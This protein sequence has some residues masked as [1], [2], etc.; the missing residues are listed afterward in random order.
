MLLFGA[1][2]HAKVL[3]SCLRAAD[4]EI[5]GIF[6][7]APL[8]KT[9]FNVPFPGIYDFGFCPDE[10]L[11]IAIGD[12]F[13][14]RRISSRIH[15]RFGKL[16][17]PSAIIDGSVNVLEGS[18]ILHRSVLQADTIVGRHVIINTGAVVEHDCVIEDFVHLAPGVIACGGV[19]IGE[20]TLIGAGSIIAQNLTIGKNCLIA[21]GSVVT[22][23]I[24]DG[25]VARGNPARVIRC[26]L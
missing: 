13:T 21:A 15:H 1:G 17:H 19:K 23:Y 7:D 9:P 25:A 22:T 5:N 10:S 26:T 24:P 6:D 3:L 2:G 18:V 8:S 11:I 14:R 12:N 4:I 20:N 16:L